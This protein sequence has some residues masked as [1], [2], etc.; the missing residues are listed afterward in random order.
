M[1]GNSLVKTII[2]V[3]IVYLASFL[4]PLIWGKKKIHLIPFLIGII[5]IAFQ[6]IVNRDESFSQLGF[7]FSTLDKYIWGF[8]TVSSVLAAVLWTGYTTGLLR[9]REK[10]DIRG[11]KKLSVNIL[12]QMVLNTVIAIFTEELVFRGLIQRQLTQA[13]SPVIAIIIASAIFGIWHIPFGKFVLG[14]N[15]KQVFMYALGSGLA[16]VVFGV[17]YYKSGSLLISGFVHGI[18]NGTVYPIWGLGDGFSGLLKSKNESLSHPEYGI[19]GIIVVFFAVLI[20]LG[21]FL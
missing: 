5:G 9:V 6:L 11:Y 8:L 19:I 20:L 3:I 2:I 4:L 10:L 12:L 15:K 18:W 21:I 16:G 7:R 17:F 14:L 1:L 13:V